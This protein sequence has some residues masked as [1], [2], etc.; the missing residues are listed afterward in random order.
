MEVYRRSYTVGAEGLSTQALFKFLQ[1]IAGEQCIPLKLSGPDLE[2]RGLMWVIIKY[3]L[4][5]SRWPQ[6]GETIQA[7]T[8]PGRTRHGMMPRY[9]RLLDGA[10]SCIISGSSVWSVVDRQTRKMVIPEEH[11]VVLEALTTGLEERRP[12]APAR[13]PLSGSAEY[14]VTEDVL[15]TNGHMNNTRYYDLAERCIGRGAAHPARIVTE[16]QSEIRLGQSMTVSWGQEGERFFLEGVNGG[17]VFRMELDYG[18]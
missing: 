16:H 15:D 3:R 18:A 10:G 4:Q 17:P 14:T 8:W 13:L 6:P 12:P 9:Y 7:N 5:V 11:G 1:D 2:K